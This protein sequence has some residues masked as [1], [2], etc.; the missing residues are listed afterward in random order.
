MSFR[1]L[2][3]WLVPS[4]ILLAPM[5]AGCRPQEQ[6]SRY[7]V[8]KPHLVDP[9]LVSTPAAA[10]PQQTLGAITSVGKTGW[11]FKLTGDPAVVGEQKDAF[12]EFVK[13]LQFAGEPEPQ[14][15]WML[16]AGWTEQPG[17]GLRFATINIPASPKPL[18]LTVIPLPKTEDGAFVL[19]NVNRWRDQLG[20]AAIN[21]EGLKSNTEEI[22]VGEQ[23]V[24]L[25]DIRGES[26]GSGMGGAAAPFAG[27]GFSSP[28]ADGSQASEISYDKPPHWQDGEKNEFRKAAFAVQDGAASVEITVIALPSSPLLENVNRWRGQ[29]SLPPLTADELAKEVKKLEVDGQPADYVVLTGEPEAILGVLAPR[30]DQTWFIKLKGDAA[31]AKR[32]ES[33]FESFVKSLKFK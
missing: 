22:K 12:V 15:K 33:H 19:S 9:T 7:T 25:V 27:S 13:S 17:S 20:L 28:R 11:F 16:P 14:P 23:V 29:I 4:A 30:G 26:T 8:P 5:A 10:V 21:A 32:E 1:R 3:L 18:E 24:T 6:I 2:N 31:L